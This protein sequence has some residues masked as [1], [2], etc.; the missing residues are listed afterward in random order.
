MQQMNV[1]VDLDLFITYPLPEGGYRWT[2]TSRLGR[3]LANAEELYGKRDRDYTIL[4]IEFVVDH[5]RIWYPGSAK[6]IIIQLGLNALGDEVQ[7]CYQL[8]HE[9][10]HLLAPS[11][12]QSANVL[13]EGLATYYSQVFVLQSFGRHMYSSLPAYESAY[14]NLV[15]LLQID[16]NA[17]KVLRQEEPSM[18]K[19]TPDLILKHYPTIGEKLAEQLTSQFMRGA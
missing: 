3:M 4:G 19:F 14:A 17:V 11:G 5:P 8:A 12:G 15:K 2:L 16:A 1:K 9:C 6:D 18:W 10:I 7:A 13:E